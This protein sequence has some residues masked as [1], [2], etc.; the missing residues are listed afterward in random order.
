MVNLMNERGQGLAEYAFLISLVV[1][2]VILVL[3]LF[4]I[5]VRDI[6]DGFVPLLVEIF[7][8]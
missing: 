1:V 5:S 4:G 6:Y 3:S 7:T 8:G 2:V